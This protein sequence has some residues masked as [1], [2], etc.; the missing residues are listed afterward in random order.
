[1]DIID[2]AKEHGLYVGFSA[3]DATRTDLNFLKKRFT[4]K[5]KKEK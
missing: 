4:V 2:Y 5:H 1:M 3:E